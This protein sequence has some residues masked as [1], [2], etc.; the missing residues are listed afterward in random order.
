L[1]SFPGGVISLKTPQN[2]NKT[3]END[4]IMKKPFMPPQKGPYILWHDNLKTTATAAVPGVTAA[5][6]TALAA[7]NADLHTKQTAAQTA[8]H[9]AIAAHAAMDASIAASKNQ[10]RPMVKNIKN[11]PAY[12]VESGAT[13]NIEGAEDTTDM[14]QQQPKL[15]VNAKSNGVVEV[16]FNKMLAEGVHIQ[17]MRD[18]DAGYG[19]LASETHTPYIDNR[20]LQVAGKPETRHYKAVFF[21]NKAEVG[22]PSDVVTATA[23]P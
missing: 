22:N 1:G 11:N 4:E 16:G 19:F 3:T 13:L 18:G 14:T 23:Q 7:A 5:D 17:T 8:E 6:V 21:M 12:T 10:A 9:A 15:T 20:P 2:H